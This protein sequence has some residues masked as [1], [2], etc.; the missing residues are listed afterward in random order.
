MVKY[1]ETI[2]L[3]NDQLHEQMTKVNESTR[4]TGLNRKNSK[5]I[6]GNGGAAIVLPT[7]KYDTRPKKSE[8][9]M[10][11]ESD[12]PYAVAAAEATDLK[13]NPQ[14]YDRIF[15]VQRQGLL[16]SDSSS[17]RFEPH[18]PQRTRQM[19]NDFR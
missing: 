18:K 14:L 19:I 8:S 11:K 17:R 5:F 6:S 9:I 1:P 10:T 13:Q 16:G 15:E 4:S 2:V 7:I 3:I 12:D